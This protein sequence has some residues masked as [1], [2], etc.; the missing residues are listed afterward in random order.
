MFSYKRIYSLQDWSNTFRTVEE[1][2][3]RL[4]P[5]LFKSSKDSLKNILKKEKFNDVIINQLGGIAT[6]VNY[7][8][9][10]HINGFVGSIS[11]AGAYGSLWNVKNGNKQ[12]PAKLLELS[13][14]KVKLNTQGKTNYS[15]VI[16]TLEKLIII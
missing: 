16:F 7:N 9:D 12:I 3:K 13:G 2:I 10:A 14:A 1:F 6:L 5:A 11:L 8:Q 4:S 15:I